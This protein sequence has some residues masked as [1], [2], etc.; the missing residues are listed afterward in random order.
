MATQMS[1]KNKIVPGCG[2]HHVALKVHDFDKSVAFYKEAL[3]FQEVISWGEGNE[4]AVMLDIGDGGC[5]ELFAGG[6]PGPKP[7]GMVL[8]VAFRTTD[9]EAALKRALAAGAEQTMAPTHVDIPSKP[10]MTPVK[11]AFC[12][13]PG[14]EIVE[15]F[16]YD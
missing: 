7:E 12:R 3:G 8:H 6:A 1:S 4:R 9:C 11:I 2:F 15:F 10:Q 5:V 14:G 16:Q 13:A